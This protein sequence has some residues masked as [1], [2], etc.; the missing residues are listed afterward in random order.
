MNIMIINGPN[1]N[2]LGTREP[3][4]YGYETYN[5]LCAYL[6]KLSS[7]YNFSCTI[8]Q[9]NYEGKIIDYLQEAM[10]NQYDGVIINPGAYAHY[11]YAIMDAL[12]GMKIKKVEV[13]LTDITK[14]ESFRHVSVTSQKCDKV[15]MGEHFESYH[16]AILYLVKG[17][18]HERV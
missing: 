4:I 3:N 1:L 10:T 11:S 15:F 8:Y 14:R 2:M 5:D 13:H 6:K 16:K 18:I 17:V 12:A 7:D 9:T